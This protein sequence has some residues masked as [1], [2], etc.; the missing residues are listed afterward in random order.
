MKKNQTA[1]SE[2]SF[3]G[4]SK[5]PVAPQKSERNSTDCKANRP[6]QRR[7]ICGFLMPYFTKRKAQASLK[8]VGSHWLLLTVSLNNKKNGQ[9]EY[10][11]RNGRNTAF[12]FPHFSHSPSFNSPSE[13]AIPRNPHADQVRLS[14]SECN[15]TYTLLQT[16]TNSE[17]GHKLG[18]DGIVSQVT[19]KWSWLDFTDRLLRSDGLAQTG[20]V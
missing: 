2:I 12:Y 18:R 1:A 8:K 17:I 7:V 20:L 4:F 3:S 5:M 13:I 9:H 11:C 6:E 10:Y 15:K 19:D 16:Q 14:V